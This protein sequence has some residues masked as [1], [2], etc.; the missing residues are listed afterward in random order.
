MRPREGAGRLLLPSISTDWIFYTN[1]VEKRRLSRLF[2]GREKDGPSSPKALPLSHVTLPQ[3]MRKREA[4]KRLP[5]K[6][7]PSLA[8][9]PGIY[10]SMADPKRAKGSTDLPAQGTI[11]DISVAMLLKEAFTNGAPSRL[12]AATP[13]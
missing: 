4:K 12:F 6:A 13:F 3:L 11:F 2:C 5:L 9:G 1:T 7:G 8:F 10:A